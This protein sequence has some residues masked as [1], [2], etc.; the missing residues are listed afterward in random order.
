MK[1]IKLRSHFRMKSSPAV[2]GIVVELHH[3]PTDLTSKSRNHR[4]FWINY[5]TVKTYFLLRK[6]TILKE[7]YEIY[8]TT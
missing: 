6:T 1:S 4:F 5:K 3:M 2:V 8:K 7:T